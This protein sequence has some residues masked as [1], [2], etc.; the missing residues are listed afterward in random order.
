MN[1]PLKKTLYP[2]ETSAFVMF[3]YLIIQLLWPSVD[4]A[5]LYKKTFAG[6]LSCKS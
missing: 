4:T 5:V 2:I 3:L 6:T 1:K